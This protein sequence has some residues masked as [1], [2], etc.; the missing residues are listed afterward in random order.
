VARGGAGA[1]AP[2]LAAR[3]RLRS[4]LQQLGSKGFQAQRNRC[5]SIHFTKYS[6]E[7]ELVET[8]QL[9][10]SDLFCDLDAANLRPALEHGC[11]KQTLS[12]GIFRGVRQA[13]GL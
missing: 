3:P 7:F 2:L 5:D 11:G 1:K 10:S 6:I 9:F 8:N 13:D 12:A 4:K